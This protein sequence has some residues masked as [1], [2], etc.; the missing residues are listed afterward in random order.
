MASEE[1]RVTLIAELRDDISAGVADLEENLGSATKTVETAGKRQSKAIEDSS[2]KSQTAWDKLNAKTSAM[3]K[4]FEKVGGKNAFS[5]IK[6]GIDSAARRV[7]D[8]VTGMSDDAKKRL[9]TGFAAAGTAAGI[10]LAAGIAGAVAKDSAVSLLGAQMGLDPKQTKRLGTLAGKAY[11]DGYGASITEV[12]DS[13]RGVLGAFGPMGDKALTDAAKNAVSIAAIMGEDV[14][15]ITTT[16][17]QLVKNGLA[18][19]ATEAFDLLTAASQNTGKGFQGDLLDATSEYGTFFASLGLKGPEALGILTAA[20]K[21]GTIGLDKAGDALKEFS[22]LATET[23]NTAVTDAYNSLGLN[24]QDMAGKLLAGGDTARGAFDRIVSGLRGMKDP[25]EQAMTAVALFGTPLEDL[26]KAKIPSFLGSLSTMDSKLENTAGKASDV[27]NRLTTGPASALDKIKRKAMDAVSGIAEAVLP[28][29]EPVLGFFTRA[30]P[31]IL[32]AAVGFGVL[33][34]ATWAANAALT[35][36]AAGGLAPFLKTLPLVRGM[37]MAWAA[38]QWLLN[39]ALNANPI[40]IVV[41]ALAALV[42]GVVWAYQNVEWFRDGVNAV[43]SG[44]QTAVGAV[45]DWFTTY[46]WPGIKAVLGFLGGAFNAFWMLASGVFQLL[47]AAIGIW[48]TNTVLPVFDAVVW[49]METILGPAFEWLYENVIKPVWDGISAVISDVW[50][51]HIKPVF[52]TMMWF[53]QEVIP[54]A[55]GKGVEAVGAIW[56]GIKAIASAPVNFV[57]DTVINDGIIKT[58][59]KVAGFLGVDPL[60]YVHNPLKAAKHTGVST[61]GGP[62]RAFALGGYTGDGGVHQEA[63]VVHGKEYV[64]DADTTRRAGGK[65][66]MD[67]LAASLKGGVGATPDMNHHIVNI[68]RKQGKM[69]V[70]AMGSNMS[71]WQLPSA[72]AAWNGLS[73][74]QTYMGKDYPG[75]YGYNAFIPNSTFGYHALAMAGGN[76]ITYNT[77]GMG[78][79]MSPGMKRAVSIHE[80]GHIMGLGHDNGHSIMQPMMSGR[81]LNPTSRDIGK[82]QGIYGPPRSGQARSMSEAPPGDSGGGDWF[83][84]FAGIMD[85]LVSMIRDKFSDTFIADLAVGVGQKIFD[86]IGSKFGI[87]DTGGILQPGRG[88]VNLSGKPERV[89]S[90]EETVKFDDLVNTYRGGGGAGTVVNFNPTLNLTVNGDADPE[91]IRE[92]WEDWLEEKFEELERTAY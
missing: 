30:A 81:I 20:S 19:S 77:A 88:A 61:S 58:F 79:G 28:V 65:R 89:L 91:A 6:D 76:A 52:D 12:G 41:L 82:L 44:I 25:A 78:P 18:G 8:T 68:L 4:V 90:P 10:A 83:N 49:F 92:E 36:Q 73:A 71:Q 56:E 31:L 85:G 2:R 64:F 21:D 48:W 16:A 3:E 51:A 23:D 42:A 84:P 37:T 15:K 67:A 13:F 1:G 63:G 33:A 75:V 80:L 55:F 70:S 34:G 43:W 14:S 57:I 54:A 53:I 38:A 24:A 29:V 5:G 60:P 40:G 27:A 87:F 50:E 7:R 26:D 32:G 62:K 74:L 22:I 17:G 45:V 66:G 59:N 86:T 72:T 9:K 46:V 11:A 39:A 69:S 35:V 47:G